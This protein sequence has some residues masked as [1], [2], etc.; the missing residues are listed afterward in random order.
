VTLPRCY[1]LPYWIKPPS[2]ARPAG[3]PHAAVL[4]AL[5]PLGDDWDFLDT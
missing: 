4:A 2:A 5:P 1:E 3:G